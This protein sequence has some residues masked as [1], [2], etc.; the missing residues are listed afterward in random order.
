MPIPLVLGVMGTTEWAVIGGIIVLLFGASK[1]PQLARSMGLA[2]KEYHQA[3]QE[4][5]EEIRRAE[6]T[7]SATGGEDLEQAAEALGIDTEGKTPEELREAI[8]DRTNDA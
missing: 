5:E 7:A 1:L 6:D 2:Q 3:K 8:R 4:A